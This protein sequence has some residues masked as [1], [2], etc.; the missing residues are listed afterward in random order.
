MREFSKSIG[1]LAN[2]RS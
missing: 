1:D 2:A